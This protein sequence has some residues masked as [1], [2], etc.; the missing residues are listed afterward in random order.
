MDQ[1]FTEMHISHRGQD[2]SIA[3]AWKLLAAATFATLTACGGGGGSATDTSDSSRD[4][5][6]A[7]VVPA[8]PINPTNLSHAINASNDVDLAW[9][10]NSADEIAFSIFRK[11]TTDNH[12]SRVAYLAADTETWTDATVDGGKRYNYYVLANRSGGSLISNT[13]TTDIIPTSVTNSG[14]TILLPEGMSGD[15]EN[16]GI[17]P[18]AR[19]DDNDTSYGAFAIPQQDGRNASIIGAVTRFDDDRRDFFQATLE[20]GTGIQLT[21]SDDTVDVADADLYLYDDQLNLI[22][23]SLSNNGNESLAV[24]Q[25]GNYFIEVAHQS[26]DRLKYTLS[27][28]DNSVGASD[29]GFSLSG[30]IIVGEFIVSSRSLGLLQTLGVLGQVVEGTI[31]GLGLLKIDQPELLLNNPLIGFRKLREYRQRRQLIRDTHQR[32]RFD[33]IML[34]RAL[35]NLLGDSVE[36]NVELSVAG[37]DTNDSAAAQQWGPEQIGVENAWNTTTGSSDVHV[38]VIDTGF[39]LNHRDLKHAFV[40]GWNYVD[41]NNNPAAT[42][43][44]NLQHGTHVAGIIAAQKDNGVDIAGI[45]PNVKIIPI[46]I[47]QPGC[48]CGSLYDAMQGI[49][50]AAG[51][52]NSAGTKAAV[53]AKVINLSIDLP[54]SNSNILRQTI[55]A[56]RNAGSV[57]VWAAGNNSS[58]LDV[59]DGHSLKTD[60]LMVVAAS[61]LYGKIAR[62][63][64]YGNAIDLI[65]PGGDNTANAGG[66]RIRSLGG[67]IAAD[68][69]EGYGS[70]NMQGTSQATPHVS[71][72]LALMASIWPSFSPSALEWMLVKNKLTQD[73][74]AMGRDDYHGWGR[75][76]AEKAIETAL[77][78]TSYANDMTH[79]ALR[80]AALPSEL[81]FGGRFEQ[82][83]FEIE[84]NQANPSPVTISY[85]PNW[86]NVTAVDTDEY[87][88]GQWQV[89]IDRSNFGT[90]LYNDVIVLSSGDEKLYLSISAHGENYLPRGTGIAKMLVEF[91]NPESL[92][93]E[94]FV[95]A[96]IDNNQRFSFTADG[97][98]AGDY[99]VRASSDLDNNGMYCEVGEFC[100]Y[101][102]ADPTEVTRIENSSSLNGSTIELSL[103]R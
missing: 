51:L 67:Y 99:I 76:D 85:K 10:D 11:E 84:A 42:K 100:G 21:A 50:W 5:R 102:K 41:D 62:Y 16:M 63:S 55:N 77:E 78:E 47:M 7:D 72:V 92:R 26:G 98:P 45:A 32:V 73:T 39:M 91:L 80:L 19:Q 17:D 36:P 75:I 87:G 27:F 94:H 93:R 82:L 14:A 12:Y 2:A 79:D 33:S 74:G 1:G 54:R 22:D 13:I 86:L 60:G 101:L 71:G 64:D 70:V 23:A 53:P 3:N 56:A 66:Q 103:I 38:A 29:H 46:K 65:A 35:Q 61:G 95:K 89:S 90:E 49:L 24:P 20:Q 48:V 81:N 28:H 43:D 25:N 44:L 18:S 34:S 31:E 6:A 9:Q 8:E 37:I 58:R 83:M 30:N 15:G 88:L 97:V 96:E 69:S 57:I 68:G 4:S 52:D 40:D 59:H